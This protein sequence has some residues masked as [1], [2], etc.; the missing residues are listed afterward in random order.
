MIKKID[1]KRNQRVRES[2]SRMKS[3][4]KLIQ[5]NQENKP[6]KRSQ[7]LSELSPILQ[8]FASASQ[9][10]WSPTSQNFRSDCVFVV[11]PCKFAVFRTSQNFAPGFSEAWAPKFSENLSEVRKVLRTS[12]K[13]FGVRI[14]IIFCI[15]DPTECCVNLLSNGTKMCRRLES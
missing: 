12:E 7:N 3:L 2:S 8:N 15:S 9:K 4:E 5:K 11:F 1:K 13:V 6:R 10:A 14:R